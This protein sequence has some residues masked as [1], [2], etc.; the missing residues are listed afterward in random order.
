M[1]AAAREIRLSP[2]ERAVLE[3][4]QEGEDDGLGLLGSASAKLAVLLIASASSRTRRGRRTV[5]R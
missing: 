2:E 4:V 3:A 5:P 1:F